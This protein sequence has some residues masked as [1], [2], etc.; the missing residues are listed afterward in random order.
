M[1]M[2]FIL[3]YSVIF[4]NAFRAGE[5][6]FAG[7]GQSETELLKECARKGKYIIE[8]TESY[9]ITAYLVNVKILPSIIDKHKK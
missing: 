9:P 4:V 8:E 7:V 1:F 6:D 2:Q 5:S 3:S